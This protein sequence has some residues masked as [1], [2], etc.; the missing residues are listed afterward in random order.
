VTIDTTVLEF[1]RHERLAWDAHC[2][3]VHAYHAWAFERRD[4]GA[5]VLTEGGWRGGL[6]AGQEGKWALEMAVFFR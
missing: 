4:S 3:G 5:Y 1:V 6:D 2:N